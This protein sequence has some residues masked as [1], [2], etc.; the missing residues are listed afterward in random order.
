MQARPKPKRFSV[1]KETSF[2]SLHSADHLFVTDSAEINQES[3]VD[4]LN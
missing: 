4:L 2:D 1:Y 3:F